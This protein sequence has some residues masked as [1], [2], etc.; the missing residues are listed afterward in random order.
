MGIKVN[1][2][3]VAGLGL[4]GAPGADGK[5]AYQ[6]A[7]EGGYTGTES[8]FNTL[9]ASAAPAPNAIPISIPTTGWTDNKQTFTV[10]GIPS[11]PTTYEVHLS[12]VGATNVSAAMACGIY[13][14]DEAQNSLTLAVNSVPESAFT[15]YAVVQVVIPP[16]YDPVFSNNTWAKI[17]EACQNNE[18]PDTWVADGSCYKDMEIN[19]ENY[20]IDIIGKNHDTYADGGSAPLTFQI[21]DCYDTHHMD[22]NDASVMNWKNCVMRTTHLPAILALMPVEVQ[23]AIREVQKKTSVGGQ[24]SDIEVTNDKLFLLSEVEIIGNT[25]NSFDGEGT[26]YE[27]YPT[28]DSRVKY[29]SGNAYNWWGRSPHYYYRQFFYIDNKGNSKSYG[30]ASSYGVAF[31]FCF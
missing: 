20:R 27:R 3:K 6:A 14:T 11:D 24:S 7:Q 22:P 5:S 25:L 21:H 31:A 18:I 4:P 12:Q 23:A 28:M 10:N 16:K 26:Q 30:C 19:G 2:I 29:Y 1:G 15:V 17:S 9:L 8:E 13:I